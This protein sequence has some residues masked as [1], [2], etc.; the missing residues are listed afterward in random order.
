[1]DNGERLKPIAGDPTIGI[2]E[3]SSLR[4]YEKFYAIKSPSKEVRLRIAR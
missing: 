4:R 2:L 3:E 1:M